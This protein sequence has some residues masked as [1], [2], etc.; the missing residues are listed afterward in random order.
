M[1]LFRKILI[2]AVLTAGIIA[3]GRMAGRLLPRSAAVSPGAPGTA[4]P[5]LELR[6]STNA[7]PA[8]AGD[9]AGGRWRALLFDPLMQTYGLGPKS[10]KR[11]TGFY[12][13][14]FPKGIPI[15]EYALEIERTCRARG[16]AVVQGAELRPANRGVEYLLESHGQRLKLRAVLG[17]AVMPGAARVAVVFAGLDS[18]SL[19]LAQ[20]LLEADWDKTLVLDPYS[21]NPAVKALRGGNARTEIIAEL[22]MEP[23]AYPYIDPGKHAL[24]IHHRREDVER[25]LGEALD[26]LP[27]AAGF[28]S[29]YGDRA[30][31]NQPLL[32][33]LFR[34]TAAR[35]LVFLDLTESQRSVARQAAALQGA[36]SRS[37][38][39]IADPREV[40][41][42]LARKAAYAQKAGEAV[43]VVRFSETAF[44]NLD[45]TIAANAARFDDIGLE[46]VTLSTLSERDTLLAPPAAPAPASKAGRPAAESDNAH[47]KGV[48]ARPRPTR[49]IGADKTPA[50]GAARAKASAPR[51]ASRGGARKGSAVKPARKRAE[52]ETSR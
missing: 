3:L 2:L 29:R 4:E 6:D 1:G 34:F 45:R 12:E 47:S 22:P 38:N 52:A 26:S 36:R 17:S 15:H 11:K 7:L 24:Y 21:A 46:L 23:T 32:E 48:V 25:V 18:L 19:S 16:I 37:P 8:Q 14:V 9:T 51:E 35:K 31:E 41:E 50:R 43:L 42:E 13:I 27:G 40:E 49:R 44:R 28:A 30:I 39:L 5:D 33:K 20:A 10:L